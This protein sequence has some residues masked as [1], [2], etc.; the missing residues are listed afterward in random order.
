MKRGFTLLELLIA[1]SIVSIVSTVLIKVIDPTELL[2]R[3]RDAQR[4]TDLKTLEK[5]INF[6]ITENYNSNLGDSNRTYATISGVK[7]G[8]R[9]P[10]TSVEN[11][12]KIDGTGWLPIDF[13]KLSTGVQISKLPLDPKNDNCYYY[14]YLV[15]S[16]K[17]TLLAKLESQKF[18][19]LQE[20]D[21]GKLPNFYELGDTSIVP[22]SITDS[23]LEEGT[24]TTTTTTTTTR[25][26]EILIYMSSSTYTG[27]LG[28][29]SGADS[30]CDLGTTLGCQIN[31]AFI[32]VNADDEIRDMPSNYGVDTSIPVYWY[33]RS[34]GQ[35]TLMGYNWA[36]ILDGSILASQYAGTRIGSDA[37]SSTSQDGRYTPGMTCSGWTSEGTSG[38]PGDAYATNG[39]WL[40]YTWTYC[41]NRKYLRCLCQR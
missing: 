13:T 16:T 26:P 3:S 24:T 14:V 36:D 35:K 4:L 40:S 5:A 20:N 11:P 7:A 21:N 38:Q 8:N 19:S 39:S 17:F 23:C 10:S 2:K 28:G 31:R 27:N 30:K 34:T 1:I 37:W 25:P 32:S 18:L 6:Y 29:R 9:D 22:S 33:N 12:T 15:D 41:T